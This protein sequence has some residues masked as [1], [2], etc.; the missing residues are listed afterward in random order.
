MPLLSTFGSKVYG[1]A[2]QL[3]R[4][5]ADDF[6]RTTVGVLGTSTSNHLWSAI[7]GVWIA[8]GFAATSAG[9]G[10][11]YPI[12]A[13]SF[14]SDIPQASL[15]VNSGTGIGF[16]VTDANSWWASAYVQQNWSQ[17]YSYGCTQYYYDSCKTCSSYT[18]AGACGNAVAATADTMNCSCGNG[19]SSPTCPYSSH[20]NYSSGY[21]WNAYYSSYIYP[22][23]VVTGTTYT[24]AC[25][26][27]T[28]GSADTNNCGCCCQGGSVGYST[29]CYGTNSGTHHYLRIIKSVGGTVSTATGDISLGATAAAIVLSTTGNTITAKAYSDTNKNNQIGGTL[30]YTPDSPTKGRFVGIVAVPSDNANNSVTG[31][32]VKTQL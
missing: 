7:R 11:T 3:L 20:P 17:Q 15:N 18:C 8:N 28:A 27:A 22:E 14:Q 31:F 9:A 4:R 25:G 6:A 26:N 21:C 29:T 1:F 16:W 32:E 10:D 30:T 13:I 24:C 19:T 2:A 5:I 12:A 23:Y